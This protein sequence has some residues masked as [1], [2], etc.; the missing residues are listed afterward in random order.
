M[1]AAAR[2][3]ALE[4]T[5]GLMRRIRHRRSHSASEVELPVAV[6]VWAR[7]RKKSSRRRIKHVRLRSRYARARFRKLQFDA[8][9]LDC[10]ECCSQ[11]ACGG[12]I[13]P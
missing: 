12:P 3:S 6:R 5:S 10:W 2:A 7:V 4:Y 13:V 1:I 8:E 11:Y 9:P